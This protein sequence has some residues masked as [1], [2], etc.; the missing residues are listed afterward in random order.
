MPG[1][2]REEKRREGKERKGKDR[3]GREI[4]CLNGWIIMLKL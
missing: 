3:K 1:K 4:V 2:G